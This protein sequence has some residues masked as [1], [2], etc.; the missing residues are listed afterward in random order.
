MIGRV[1]VIRLNR[2]RQMYALSDAL[3]DA[4]GLAELKLAVIPGAGGTQRLPR[5]ISKAKAMDMCMTARNMDA[6][7]AERSGLVSRVV[8]AGRLMDEA[9]LKKRG[10]GTSIP[11][12][13]QFPGKEV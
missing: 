1:A 9:M 7:E 5:A 2:P 12:G 13:L 8:A 4:F 3:M 6:A 10:G 11:Q